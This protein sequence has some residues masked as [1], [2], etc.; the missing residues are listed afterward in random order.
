[1]RQK[2]RHC[3]SSSSAHHIGS[4]SHHGDDEEDD[5]V[6]SFEE[7][8]ISFLSVEVVKV[9]LMKDMGCK[10]KVLR[11]FEMIE[12]DGRACIY[13]AF[14]SVNTD[15]ILTNDEFPILN[16]RRKIISEDNGRI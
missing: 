13:R 6:E 7:L 5:G 4:S 12:H 14:V 10:L 16:F 1:M 11:N 15:D 9:C 8:D 3:V 2:A